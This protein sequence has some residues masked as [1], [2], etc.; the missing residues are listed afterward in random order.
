MV[1]L[2]EIFGELEAREV[3]VR[4]NPSHHTGPFE[5]HEVAIER[6]LG[7]RRVGRQEI[8]DAAW[9]LGGG[10]QLDDGAPPLR[11]SLIDRAEPAGDEH[12][13]FGHTGSV[14]VIENR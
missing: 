12:V 8:G 10:K 1:M 3:A 5:D 2:S 9:A 14:V 13:E 7:E 6:A 4:E 11:V